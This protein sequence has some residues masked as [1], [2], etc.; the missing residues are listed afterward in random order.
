MKKA[1]Q[2]YWLK[3]H[4]LCVY[5][6]LSFPILYSLFIYV[7]LIEGFFVLSL[8]VIQATNSYLPSQYSKSGE[9]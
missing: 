8:N 5:I 7:L 6:K 2:M 1:I 3:Q 9:K 4:F